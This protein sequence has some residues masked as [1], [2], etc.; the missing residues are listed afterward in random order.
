MPSGGTATPVDAGLIAR[1]TRGMRALGASLR[2]NEVFFGPDE[3]PKVDA[4]EGSQRV[5]DYATGF[6]LRMTPQRESGV[7]FQQLRSLADNCDLVRLAIETRKDQMCRLSWDIRERNTSGQ[8]KPSRKTKALREMWRFP[9]GERPFATWLR[10]LC[11]EMFVIDAVVAQPLKTRGGEMRGLELIDGA[12]IT[13]KIDA[14]GR[15]PLPPQI[16]YQQIIKGVPAAEWD[17]DSLLYL[18]RNQRVSKVYGY[19]HVEQIILTVNIALRRQ[20]HQL[21]YYTEG[22]IPEALVGV[23]AE[24][25]PDQI[26]EFQKYWDAL[27]EGDVAQKR[28]MRF[29]PGEIAKSYVPT[30]EPMMKD[31]FDEWLAR[32]VCYT[33]SLP[34]TP[35]IRQM[36]RATAESSSISSQEEGI[37]P[38]K[39]FVKDAIDIALAKF[40]D[41]PDHEF[42]F[43]YEASLDR[44]KQAQIHKTY[45]D[46]GVINPNEARSEIGLAPRDGGDDFVEEVEE[47]KAELDAEMKQREAK[48]RQEIRS[49]AADPANSTS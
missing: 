34:P 46:G 22:N 21:A 8:G 14:A 19:S 23:P 10:M 41:A 6:N 36:N 47:R 28:H 39:V 17:R 9:D 30:R 32:I 38:T 7:T 44:L 42:V 11:E 33:F 26:A 43:K 45:L 3:P 16:A 15:T 27:I 37:E 48:G 5:F 35:L 29:V 31:E 13:R 20:M 40:C 25:S 18:M 49:N 1:L 12:T 24:W 4:P 2:G